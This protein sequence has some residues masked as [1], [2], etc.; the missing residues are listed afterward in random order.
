MYPFGI[1]ASHNTKE[2]K[3]HFSKKKIN[4][5]NR[6]VIL[7]LVIRNFDMYSDNFKIIYLLIF[8]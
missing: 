8:N 4:N 6:I 5:F 7:Y 1:R 3:K 2:N